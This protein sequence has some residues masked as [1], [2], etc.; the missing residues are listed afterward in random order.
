M[1]RRLFAALLLVNMTYILTNAAVTF[2]IYSYL[3]ERCTCGF[4]EG[5]VNTGDHKV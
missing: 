5:Y 3:N 1:I 4:H 2:M